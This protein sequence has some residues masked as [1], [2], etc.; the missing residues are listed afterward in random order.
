MNSLT[1]PCLFATRDAA[2][3]FQESEP[4]LELMDSLSAN[5]LRGLGFYENGYYAISNNAKE[6]TTV[7][8]LNNLKLRS[9]TSEMAIKS[10]ECLNVQPVA[11]AFW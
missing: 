8:G 9:M 2:Y 7:D 10:W 1:L 3:A 4:V 11:M 5:G 6:I